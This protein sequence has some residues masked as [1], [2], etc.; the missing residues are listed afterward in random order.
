[1]FF[2]SILTLGIGILGE[3]IGKIFD[4]S[5]LRPIYIRKSI[6]QGGLIKELIQ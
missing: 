1:M 3:Y 5:K 2:G 6:I 4:E